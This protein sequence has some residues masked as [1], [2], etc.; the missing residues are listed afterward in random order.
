MKENNREKTMFGTGA[1]TENRST[2]WAT[3]AIA[4]LLLVACSSGGATT[5]T[6]GSGAGAGGD[7]GAAGTKSGAAGQGGGVAGQGGGVAGQGGGVAGQ[8]GGLAG[9]AGGG[10]GTG[11]G[12]GGQGVAGQGGVGTCN[13]P[14][15]DPE[16]VVSGKPNWTA[17]AWAVFVAP[18]GTIDSPPATL[19]AS[20]SAVWAPNHGYDTGLNEFKS[21][22]PHAPPYD[23]ELTAGLAQTTFVNTGCFPASAFAA[24]SGVM[25]SVIL[26]PS[27]TAPSGTSFEV[28]TSGP[29]IPG[30]VSID[31]DLLRNGVVIDPAFDTLYAKA[32]ALYPQV[33]PPPD[34][35]RHII[36]NFA[37]NS[38]FSGGAALTAGD[39]AFR[40]KIT[41]NNGVA[42]T[43][44]TVH[45]TVN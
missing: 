19:N 1:E 26:V 30:T 39:Y 33:Q 25:I 12:L 16:Q 5:G 8:G 14:I 22:L 44:Q 18:L 24:P 40:V 3:A 27:A 32:Y 17:V 23:G 38:E 31:G 13:G 10:A 4:S 35:F 37:E 41:D 2:R 45:F 9:H 11:G 42:S 34:G 29:I 15:V 21:I 6:G 28:P 20:F 43:S 36:L 7:T